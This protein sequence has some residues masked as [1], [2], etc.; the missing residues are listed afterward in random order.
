VFFVTYTFPAIVRRGRINHKRLSLCAC[1]CVY[2]V[3]KLPILLDVQLVDESAQSVVAVARVRVA[4]YA[5]INLRTYFN[6][7]LLYCSVAGKL[8]VV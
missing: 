2:N 1:A 4:A 6:Y 3:H 5:F 8:G 7:L